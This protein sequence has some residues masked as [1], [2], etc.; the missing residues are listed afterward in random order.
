MRPPPPRPSTTK[1][2]NAAVA[3]I[4]RP[5]GSGITMTTVLL[6][7][8]FA[9]A[10]CSGTATA[11]TP[12]STPPP[13]PVHDSAPTHAPSAP[14]AAIDAVLAPQVRPEFQ[15]QVLV[16]GTIHLANYRDRLQAEHLESLL[17][18]LEAF[19]PTHIAVEALTPDELAILAEREAHDPA[20]V[21][22]LDMFG[23]GTVTAG[24]A[25]QRELGVDRVA[26]ERLAR[27]IL[28]RGGPPRTD[29][30]RL[31]AVAH[32]LAAYDFH[33]AALQWTYLSPE[34][35]A[36]GG[37]IPADL[38]ARL[39][40]QLSSA[41]EIATI[42]GVLARR[43]GHQRLHSMD[44]QYDGVRMLSL[45]RDELTELMGHPARSQLSDVERRRM[46][47]AV[48][49]AAFEA[50][51]LLPFYLHINGPEHQ[52]D[53]ATQWNWLFQGLFPDRSD[54]LRYANWEVRNLRQ[55][56]HV[57]DIA[58]A[59][60]AERVLVIVGAS[61]KAAVERVLATQL[62]VRLVQLAEL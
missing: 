4:R 29:D 1:S 58:A 31:E 46:T 6:P 34:A 36:A 28:D 55:A 24:A 2:R 30:E 22:L 38:R 49:D 23:R 45:P 18:R 27:S 20:A 47:D 60:G 42:A 14:G 40:R 9:L 50:G 17:A 5:R 8:L 25:M 51:D 3:D 19:A 52:E 54:R 33:S 62:T 48:R 53:D 10:S 44:S 15:A 57:V 11:G 12:E 61:H 39:D 21:E 26:A 13:S 56:T 35:R 59:P 16:L 37:S 32:L 43:L 41:N 7:L